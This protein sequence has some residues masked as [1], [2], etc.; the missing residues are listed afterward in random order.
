MRR[1]LRF[2]MAA[3]VF[4][5][6]VG[7]ATMY[8]GVTRSDYGRERIRRLALQQLQ[9]VAHGRVS[10]ERLEGNVLN[11][12]A[13]V[14]VSIADSNG[15]PFFH[16]ARVEGRVALLPL[17]RQRVEL[18]NVQV[19]VPVIVLEQE[20][21]GQWNYQRIFAKDSAP[22]DST[23][24]FGDWVSLRDVAVRG[25]SVTVIRP[26][27]PERVGADI[28]ASIERRGSGW[29][30]VM[31]FDSLSLVMP[32]VIIADP[33]TL[34]MRFE[35]DSA[36]TRAAVFRPPFLHVVNA[37][38]IL[39]LLGDTV[40][41]DDMQLALPSSR[42]SGAVAYD[43]R[44]G[45]VRAALLID[46]LA[47]HDVR[48]L[49]PALPDSGG[50]TLALS[51]VYSD[52]SA[53]T[54]TVHDMH[55]RVGDARV[56]G[57]VGLV[58]HD[59]S[60]VLQ[61]TDVEFANLPTALIT[62]LAPDIV[63][64]FPA[65]VDGEVRVKGRLDALTLE[66]NSRVHPT[67]HAPFSLTASGTAGMQPTFS[68]RNLHVQVTR[69][70]L[71]LLREFNV[72]QPVQ[73][74]VS[75]E[76]VV[77]GDVTRSMRGRV[78]IHHSDGMSHSN[79]TLNGTVGLRPDVASDVRAELHSVS[80]TLANYFADGLDARGTVAGDMHV[81]G[82]KQCLAADV[83]LTVPGSGL[84][85][86]RG[87]M[88]DVGS[89][90]MAYSATVELV[91][92]R[93]E[94]LVPSVPAMQVTGVTTLRG[95]GTTLPTLSG[96]LESQ[97]ALLVI[98]STEFQ[99]VGVAVHA[100]A[101]LL[102]IDSVSAFTSFARLDAR[103]AFGLV[104]S[105]SGQV[106]FDLN[107]TD[108][109]GLRRFAGRRDSSAIAARPALGVRLARAL[110][111]ED[112][113]RIAKMTATDPA[114]ALAIDIMKES[115]PE[116][117]RP[118]VPIAPTSADSVAGAVAMHGTADGNVHAT[119][120]A[121]TATTEGV[122]WNGNLFGAGTV[123]GTWRNALT[124]ADTVHVE[125]GVDSLRVAGFALDS[126]K[127]ALNYRRGDGDLQL[128]MFPGDTAV[129]RLD[130]EF[131]LKKDQGELRFKD[132]ELRLDSAAWRTTGSSR[133]SWKGNTIRIDSL[134]LRDQQRNARLF[135][136]GNLP[137]SDPGQVDFIAENVRIAPWLTIAQTDV[138]ADGYL[139]ARATVRGT[140]AAP[141]IDGT[142]RIDRTTYNGT[143]FP[144]VR[145]TTQYAE[146][147]LV[148]DVQATD[149]SGKTVATV[150]GS[151]P[152][153]LAM[154][155]SL[156]T[157]LPVQGELNV[158][159]VGDSIPLS[160]L[161]QFTDALTD[162]R[163]AAEINVT[164][165]G[166]W[167]AVH[168]NGTASVDLETARVLS[169]GMV[170]TD[171][172]AELRM[173][174]DTVHIVT[175]DATSAGTIHGSGSLVL[176]P[177]NN[178]TLDLQLQ[179]NRA[180]L[181]NDIR[182]DILANSDVQVM[183]PLDSLTVTGNVA[184]VSGLIFLPD[185]SI[186]PIIDA[187]DPLVYALTDSMTV[188][189]LELGGPTAVR[190]NMLLDVDV[191]VKRGTFARSVDANVEVFGDVH[192]RTERHAPALIVTGV[193]HTERGQYTA[194]G[195]R[196]DMQRGSVRFIGG[197]IINP[198]LQLIAVYKVQQAGRPPLDIRVEVGGTLQKPEVLLASDAQPT[199]SQSDLIA[200]LAFGQGSTALL[201]FSGTGLE[202]GGSGGS[203]LAG[204]VAALATRQLASIGIGAVMDAVR[205][206]LVSSTGADVLNIT[207]AQ[208]PA[209]VNLSALQ[210]VLRGTE[211]EIGRYV[212]NRTFVLGR[213][214]PSLTVPGASVEH[215]FSRQLR[216]VASLETIITARPPSLS[217]GVAPQA[218]PVF[219]GLFTWSIGW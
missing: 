117:A 39:R 48:A 65:V 44:L 11:R 176:S 26:I 116:R 207:P 47:F 139:T 67:R 78:Q 33:A 113:L 31:R 170:L 206:D 108:V 109:G 134:E 216:G 69:V 114:A 71:S 157:R 40:A 122:V 73:G 171:A 80:L 169:T 104:D 82:T 142:I 12:F 168:T 208:L 217:L 103:G 74:V 175:L 185:V 133:V 1:L 212:N 34:G 145:A 160:P 77:S 167:D 151:V 165:R 87:T 194:F 148:L 99:H 9:A 58:L 118:A 126:T 166:T 158:R 41:F 120:V 189:E 132:I 23:Q 51:F 61:D 124:D 13:L 115:Q 5:T 24:G 50:G 136:N 64:P 8:V 198:S 63:S 201:Q 111:R 219:G 86:T 183:G 95:T 43:A 25:G 68:A 215:R 137:D 159:I 79:A 192:V 173:A 218:R 55:V 128:A 130:T 53:S 17:L 119:N 146:Q 199:L 107:V 15:A 38:G 150:V 156:A 100:N 89:N 72:E 204:N 138:Q 105:E 174:D 75:A 19:A 30:R 213:V 37:A 123:R 214:R 45:D 96:D 110:D 131:A 127:F 106:A 7:I 102:T 6:V 10:V 178:P 49:Y 163:G 62:Q 164:V 54:Y 92:V 210:T 197:E 147:T 172:H 98:D 187:Q 16:A 3:A 140:T 154:G 179:T 186:E 91:R 90:H 27:T 32:Q 155:D 22:P 141:L 94:L 83:T 129:Y 57:D 188:K 152:L 70:P 20:A 36:R 143:S 135:I 66:L 181:L 59:S 46:T 112:S 2:V 18:S 101:G 52:S 200:F 88:L 177:L 211:I 56:R 190:E 93:P 81:S 85:S 97:L 125:G 153:N 191:T 196:F 203:S 84:V 180:R 42:L 195:K 4:V 202:G 60:V 161:A 29:V 162:V 144:D 149:T 182:G 205:S 76:G 184:V 121:A 209:D 35:I 21:K 193:L 28:R 14:N